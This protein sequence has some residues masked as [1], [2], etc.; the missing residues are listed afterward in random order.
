VDVVLEEGL[1]FEGAFVPPDLGAASVTFLG[2]RF[3]EV[4]ERYQNVGFF[5]FMIEDTSRGRVLLGPGGKP[6]MTYFMND[7][8]VARLKRGMEILVRVFIA[9]G[10]EAVFTQMKGFVE[11]TDLRDLE[12]FRRTRHHARDFDLTAHHPLGT[13]HMGVDPRSSVV[14]PTHEAHDLPGLFVCDG[15]AVPSSIGVN[16]MMTIM[17]MA[18]RAARFI[19]RRVEDMATLAA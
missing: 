18:T 14:G 11:V 4:M 3:T 6:V 7:H 1:L 13:C 5:G 8:D 17:A 2:P 16:P 19:A 15:S 10:A 12:R 9:A